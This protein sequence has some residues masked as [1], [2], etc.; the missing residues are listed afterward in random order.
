VSFQVTDP[1]WLW[2]LPVA[3]GWVVWL[4]RVSD[5]QI[6][7]V[8]RWLALGFRVVVVLALI[9]AIAGLQWRTLIE[10]MNV[11]FVLDRSDSVPETRQLA[12]RDWVQQVGGE[13]V[14]GDRA[15][16]VVFGSEAGVENPVDSV[17]ELRKSGVV[18]PTDRTDISAA[19]RLAA[20]AF[21]EHG[22]RRMVLV[23][24]GNE[25][26]GDA[27]NAAASA[28]ALEINVDVI[29]A[30]GESKA[31]VALRRLQLPARVKQGQ[32][33]EAK[34][35]VEADESGPATVRLYRN[36]Q[37]LGEQQIQLEVGKNL[38][39]FPQTL[40][41]TG[42]YQYDVRVF[43]ANDAMPQNNRAF[44]F[45]QVRGVPRVLVVSDSPE[46]DR[47]LV[48][49]LRSP[50]LEVRITGVEGFPDSL[51]ELQSYDS[52]ILCN[53][54][55]GDLDRRHQE[56]LESAV[57]D[58]GTGFVCVGGDRTY[59][60][61]AYRGTPLA[62]VLPVEVELS[63]RKVL[64]PGA[65]VLVIDKSGS[66][67]GDKLEMA[68]QSAMGAVEALGDNDYVG[69]IAFDGEPFP[70]AHI[71]R[72]ANRR[73]IIRS[74]AGLE[75][76]GGTTMYPPLSHARD[77]LNSVTASFK[78]CI[79]LT[80]GQSNPGDFEGLAKAM[81]N[82]RITLSTVGV[83]Q[84]T[85]AAFLEK[86]AS[87]GRGRFYYVPNPSQ[88][89]QVFIKETAVVLKAA[90]NEEPFTP[91]M[92]LSTE[93]V[94]GISGYPALLGHVVTEP[95]PRA[96][97]PLATDKGDPLL[98][99][100]QYGLG[101]SVAFTSDARTKWARNW[102]EWASYQQFWT[103]VVKW[104]LRR[105]ENA[106]LTAEIVTERGEGRV[107]VDALDGS[108][109]F[110]NFLNLEGTVVD[111]KG[112]RQAVKLRQTGPGHYEAAFPMRDSG[113]YLLNLME[114]ENGR[115]RAAQVVGASLNYSPE[116]EA[117]GPNLNLLRRIAETTGGK[118]LDPTQPGSNP[119]LDDR[120]PTWRP[121]DLWP[122]LLQLAIILFVLDVGV[123]RIHPDPE[124]WAKAG[125]VVLGFVWF[126][127]K[128][129]IPE[130]A[131]K[132]SLA[133]MLAR[134]DEVRLQ[135]PAT[136]SSIEFEPAPAA[137]TAPR[138]VLQAKLAP[139]ANADPAR[140]LPSPEQGGKTSTAS[141][142]LEA[143]RKSRSR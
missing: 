140:D 10:G 21:P 30:G 119:F 84:D 22:Q 60:A 105:L 73:Q 113:A 34:V 29:P 120:R 69:V 77:M 137:P 82:D 65:L 39:T 57:R 41:E 11:I 107:S 28:R 93:P 128:S 45:T 125:R 76:S 111:P 86:L 112:E 139:D 1:Q 126:W 26:V 53:I 5:V 61:G 67:A 37:L 116:L 135:R 46:S 138:P 83:G 81:V 114:M 48:D 72:A 35:F 9:L 74:I 79:A 59:A 68:K 2:L 96:E 142:L 3:V 33:F 89:P 88:L 98:A 115:P 58:F 104:S 49:A 7:P 44:A 42:F 18:L 24:D 92:V 15:G 52:V 97:T 71:Q 95:K 103:Q 136:L 75:A 16:V 12:A 64:P 14:P 13:K 27:L 51:P 108:G 94:R 117:G 66:M 101:R 85:D 50:D 25:N 8:R 131:S 63:S 20:A 36:E 127:R 143:R 121:H 19:I 99:H 80:D 62:S 32:T 38:L 110:N 31:D 54:A 56:M 102:V 4:A 132:P 109:H 129:A 40:S 106:D 122:A 91:Q 47:S 6:H 23:S 78:H 134:R 70:V 87:L 43:A 133:A 118:I 17:F 130:T 90:I 100:W 123:R 55:A 141:H 124:E